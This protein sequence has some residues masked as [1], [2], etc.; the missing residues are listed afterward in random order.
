MSNDDVS[1]ISYENQSMDQ[2]AARSSRSTL[3][4][5]S[6]MD[7]TNNADPT[8]DR[9]SSHEDG[10]GFF[11]GD[12]NA[13][14]FDHGEHIFDSVDDAG[15]WNDCITDDIFQSDLMCN[16][17]LDSDF[18]LTPPRSE[19]A[20]ASMQADRAINEIP[21]RNDSLHQYPRAYAPS[22]PS[23]IAQDL[24]IPMPSLNE[25]QTSPGTIESTSLPFKVSTD[26]QAGIHGNQPDLM[27][28]TTRSH[29]SHGKQTRTEVDDSVRRSASSMGTSGNWS[30]FLHGITRPSLDCRKR[31]HLVERPQD[32]SVRRTS[33]HDHEHSPSQARRSKQCKCSRS[34]QSGIPP[35]SS[36]S[37]ASPGEIN[38]GAHLPNMPEGSM[39]SIQLLELS[40][41][42]ARLA[43]AQ[44]QRERQALSR[45]STLR[46]SDWS[47]SCDHRS[48]KVDRSC[49]EDDDLLDYFADEASSLE[50]QDDMLFL[51]MNSRSQWSQ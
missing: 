11:S 20:P 16:M 34:Q 4:M 35:S 27:I 9:Q 17:S 7:T 28:Q 49:R 43:D 30:D 50:S 44:R 24:E 33:S 3:S 45:R 29:T 47:R 1:N 12:L 21:E 25:L 13:E 8:L 18:F 6:S 41:R 10:E 36:H 40:A 23:G 46:I 39:S 51:L 37:A 15:I 32:G 42:F 31:T 2:T 38:R 26:S 22:N 14:M 19:Q 48:P 5:A